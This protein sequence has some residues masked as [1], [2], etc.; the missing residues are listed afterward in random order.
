MVGDFEAILLWWRYVCRIHEQHKHRSR[1]IV[2]TTREVYITGTR[3]KAQT[4]V[5][6]LSS[7]TIVYNFVYPVMGTS[8]FPM[9]VI[10]SAPSSARDSQLRAPKADPIARRDA[11]PASF[12]RPALSRGLGP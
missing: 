5:N 11:W 10:Q 1:Y 6:A 12:L 8:T 9:R 4:P 2:T 7:L 3:I